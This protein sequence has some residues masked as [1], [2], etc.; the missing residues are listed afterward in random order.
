MFFW[1]FIFQIYEFLQEFCCFIIVKIVTT[2]FFL[3]FDDIFF[4]VCNDFSNYV[5]NF[6]FIFVVFKTPHSSEHLCHLVFDIRMLF[7]KNIGNDWLITETLLKLLESTQ[8]IVDT[9]TLYSLTSFKHYSCVPF[10]LCWVMFNL[11]PASV[12]YKA[13]FLTTYFEYVIILI[14]F[15]FLLNLL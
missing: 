5:L 4:W 3:R 1:W 15:G 10:I 13:D 2:T 8:M 6:F 7:R 11:V 12:V 14:E 9:W